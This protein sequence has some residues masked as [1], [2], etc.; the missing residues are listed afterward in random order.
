MQL[1]Q[2]VIS[3]TG[4]LL[5]SAGFI[6]NERTIPRLHELKDLIADDGFYVEP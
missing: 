5:L 4:Q 3:K 1:A 6:L 2:D